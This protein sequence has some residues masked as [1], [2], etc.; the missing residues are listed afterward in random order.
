MWDHHR[1]SL[2]LAVAGKP[3]L[4]AMQPPAGQE[5]LRG[6]RGRRRHQP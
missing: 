5:A 4:P 2:T 6:P 3:P 1:K